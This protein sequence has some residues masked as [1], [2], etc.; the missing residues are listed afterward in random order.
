MVEQP[1]HKRHKKVTERKGQATAEPFIGSFRLF[2]NA[3]SAEAAGSDVVCRTAVE[4]GYTSRRCNAL[5]ISSRSLC[6][7]AEPT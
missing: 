1:G 5:N 6:L 7:L 3:F 2:L 4:K